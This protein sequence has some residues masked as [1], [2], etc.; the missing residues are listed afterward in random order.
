M[1]QIVAN[2]PEFVVVNKDAGV[3]FHSQD[4]QAGIAAQLALDLGIEL[5][6]VHRLD[7]ITS[8]LLIFAKTLGAAQQ[9]G[10]MFARHQV[11]KYYLAI[12][13]NKP[14]KK[15]GSVMGD[16]AKS[17]RSQYKLLRSRVNPAITQFFSQSLV[18]GK[19]LYLLKPLSGKT[20]Q[21]R[22]ALA[23]LAV[24]ILGDKLY[25]GDDSDRAYLHAWQLSF[26]FQGQSWKFAALPSSGE[27]FAH[28]ALAATLTQWPQPDSLNWPKKSG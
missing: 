4:G 24:P 26:S 18:A 28:E 8:G 21:L 1:Y 10:D 14:T 20:H 9:F 5:Y 13:G 2:E 19:R 12:A 15:Q 22:V 27:W 16:M 3:H 11:Q 7:T 25:G 23:S 6:P 17:R